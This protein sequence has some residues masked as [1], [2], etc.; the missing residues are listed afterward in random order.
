MLFS[1]IS[2]ISGIVNYPGNV[3]CN[4]SCICIIEIGSAMLQSTTLG[5]DVSSD[6]AFSKS[7]D[8]FDII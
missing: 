2:T 7:L 5:A 4:L 6:K 8:Y 1:C 3:G